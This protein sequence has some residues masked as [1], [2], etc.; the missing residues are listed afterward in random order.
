MSLKTWKLRDVYFSHYLTS[1]PPFTFLS[2]N[3]RHKTALG[4]CDSHPLLLSVSV[5]LRIATLLGAGSCVKHTTHLPS[6][7]S[8]EH[9]KNWEISLEGILES[10]PTEVIK[11][12]PLFQNGAHA[13]TPWISTCMRPSR[14]ADL[15]GVLSPPRQ[16]SPVCL[17]STLLHMSCN[18]WHHPSSHQSI[19]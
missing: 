12:I 16:C 3:N 2:F 8:L 19:T 11:T 4:C 17:V 14:W 7:V 13:F 5:S 6:T 1:F 10:S 9:P 15:M 18:Q